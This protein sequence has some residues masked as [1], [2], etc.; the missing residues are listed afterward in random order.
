MIAL[1]AHRRLYRTPYLIFDTRGSS[2]N[3]RLSLCKYRIDIL[4]LKNI[5]TVLMIDTHLRFQT[6]SLLDQ[7]GLPLFPEL[8]E[9]AFRLWLRDLRLRCLALILILSHNWIIQ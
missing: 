2:A 4:D 9:G 1:L 8:H 3:L 5:I 6:A 7:L